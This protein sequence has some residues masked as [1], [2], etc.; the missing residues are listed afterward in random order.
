MSAPFL[1]IF[2]PAGMGIFLALLRNQ[3]L[4]VL[5]AGVTC[6]L[7]AAAALLVPID[8]ALTIRSITFK[9]SPSFVILGRRLILT[10]ID[11]AFLALIFG[12]S[13][14]W[15]MTASSIQIARRLIPYGMIITSLLVAALAVEPFLYAALIIE[16][17]VLLAVPLISTPD[18]RPGKGVLRFLIYQTLAMPF[19]LFSGWLLA[20]I[21]ANS[22]D[23]IL[24]TRSIALLGLGF[25]LLLAIFPFYTWIPLLAEETHP[26]VAGFVLWIFPTATM[27]FGLGFLDQYSW[28]R[29]SPA[30][31]PALTVV[32]AIM[33]VSGG[34][35]AMFQRHLGRLMGYAVIIET[36]FS[37]LGLGIGGNYGLNS[38]LLL[39]VPRT[40]SLQLW[41]YSLSILREHAPDL[42]LASLKGAGRKWFFS[43]SGLLLAG[44]SLAGMPL[45]AAFPAHQAIWD[46]VARQSLSAAF[47][48]LIG[49]LGLTIGVIRALTALASASEGTLWSAHETWPQRIF[50]FLGWLSLF[51][52]GLF[53][54]WASF[55]WTR[56]P[57]LFEHLGK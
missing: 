30:L 46:G 51:V 11:R 49:S 55:L 24:V 28:L 26:Y 14:F 44:F 42:T 25:A 21:E 45:L 17:A 13:T 22:V 2:L 57:A 35:L 1:W 10:D 40:I 9:L 19:I 39:L 18:R 6:A 47:W 38:F 7:L 52:I 12:A 54:Q 23:Q 31:G 33:I 4:I 43:S 50:L 34:L 3:K 16:V 20:G 41:A 53:P 36:G 48:V 37:L 27:F 15:F 56:L 8:T 5:I 29:N 32:G